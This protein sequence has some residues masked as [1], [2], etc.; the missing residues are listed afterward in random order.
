V[1]AFRTR[2]KA[3]ELEAEQLEQ[4]MLFACAQD[5]WPH[6]ADGDPRHIVPTNVRAYLKSL[7]AGDAASPQS[8][9]EAAIRT[10]R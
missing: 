8:L 9:I 6:T 10:A 4:A 5:A 2:V 1:A 3:L 7:A